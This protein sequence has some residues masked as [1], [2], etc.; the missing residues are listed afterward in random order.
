MLSRRIYI[1]GM[2]RRHLF[3]IISNPFSRLFTVAYNTG[4]LTDQALILGNR[5]F[6][7]IWL[8]SDDG[9]SDVRW[10]AAE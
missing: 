3:R 4:S 8:P 1:P 10:H 6:M 5:G 7:L 9:L 2:G